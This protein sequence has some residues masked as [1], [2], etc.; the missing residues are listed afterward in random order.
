MEENSLKFT[1]VIKKNHEFRRLYA[2]GKSAVSPYTAIYCRKRAQGQNHLGLTVG[3][4]I[5]N[6]VTR[7]RVRR[8]LREI[9]RTNESRLLPG[10]DMVIVARTKAVRA[11]YRELER[12]F[13]SKA[14]KLGF[15]VEEPL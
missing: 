8:R 11:T 3:L 12:D 13:L 7:N 14:K 6:A 15:L 5:G 2:K 10:Y 1:A 9:Y 4:K